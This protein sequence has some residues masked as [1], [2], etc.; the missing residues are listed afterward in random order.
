MKNNN[1]N[2]TERKVARGTR[3][4]A[5][6]NITDEDLKQEVFILS[7]ESD[8]AQEFHRK[9]MSLLATCQD[10]VNEVPI[11]ELTEDEAFDLAMGEFAKS[12]ANLTNSLLSEELEQQFSKLLTDRELM[13]I[14]YRFYNR[15]TLVET[16]RLLG[17]SRET[18][19][20]IEAKAL[21]KL[22]RPSS[23][24]QLQGF[25]EP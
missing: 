13:L 10:F 4:I 20:I 5:A 11:E 24:K 3:A 22:R 18:A 6:H 21:R 15:M 2:A 9:L 1:I 7:L 23:I 25:L 19:R 16:G 12:N 17:V 8:T 14:K